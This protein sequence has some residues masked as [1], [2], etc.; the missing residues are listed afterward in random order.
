MEGT[1]RFWRFLQIFVRALFFLP[2]FYF[3]PTKCLAVVEKYRTKYFCA[4]RQLQP[5][6]GF[7]FLLLLRNK[8]AILLHCLY[9]PSRILIFFPLQGVADLPSFPGYLYI[10]SFWNRW[11]L[12]AEEARGGGG[13]KKCLVVYIL[14][15][16]TEVEVKRGGLTPLPSET[17]NKM[18]VHGNCC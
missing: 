7:F 11:E 18:K 15:Q 8:V 2:F 6:R 17:G 12:L 1:K 14:M 16:G 13:L 9:K 4:S 3:A 10:F 5:A